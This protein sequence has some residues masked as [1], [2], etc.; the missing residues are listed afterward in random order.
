MNIRQSVLD[1]TVLVFEVED[2]D[3]GEMVELLKKTGYGC[4]LWGEGV[5]EPI[6]VID[7]RI[8]K[9][10]WCTKNHL[11]AIEAHELGHIKKESK[12][13]SVAELAGIELLNEKE[14]YSAAKILINRGV[15]SDEDRT[16]YL[17]DTGPRLIDV[18]SLVIVDSDGLDFEYFRKNFGLVVKIDTQQMGDVCHVLIDD[19]VIVVPE[20]DCVIML[21]AT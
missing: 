7:T 21:E 12:V 3:T 17:L 8:A 5:D 15:I 16:R 10:D 20:S 4:A 9:E 6:I 19:E 14:Y 2:G 18:G 11:L 1:E 13:E